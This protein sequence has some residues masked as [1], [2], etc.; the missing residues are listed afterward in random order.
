MTT[1]TQTTT[2]PTT[3]QLIENLGKEDFLKRQHARLLLIKRKP[4]STPLLEQALKSTNVHTRWEAARALGNIQDPETATALTA[5]LMDSDVGVRWVTMESLIGMGRNCL[6]PVLERFTRDFS[7]IWM[8]RSVHHIL[9]VLRDRHELEPLE[10]ELFNK[11]DEK[12]FLG[13]ETGVTSEQVL[14][15]QKALE[16]LTQESVQS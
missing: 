10:I 16:A 6:R 14:V 7:S 13:M 1:Q 3:S 4:E 12:N 2:E 15:A 11:L 5:L 9:H 8:R